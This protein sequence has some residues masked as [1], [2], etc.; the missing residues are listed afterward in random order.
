LNHTLI[1]DLERNWI[2][3]GMGLYGCVPV[4][5][6][7]VMKGGFQSEEVQIYFWKMGVAY[8]FYFLGGLI[9]LLRIPERWYPGHLTSNWLQSHVFWHIFVSIGSL[10]LF[11]V[12]W[13]YYFYS[14]GGTRCT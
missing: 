7:A 14:H 6:W 8:G 1:F 4:I 5:S 9:Y 3:F 12:G 10:W 13:D 2:Y 11:Y